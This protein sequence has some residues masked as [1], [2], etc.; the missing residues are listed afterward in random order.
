MV[1]WHGMIGQQKLSVGPSSITFL[2]NIAG[3]RVQTVPKLKPFQQLN[4]HKIRHRVKFLVKII[5][6]SRHRHSIECS[7]KRATINE[8]YYYIHIF[9]ER[10]CHTHPNQVTQHACW[11]SWSLPPPGSHG[12]N[13][14]YRPHTIS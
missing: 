7:R 8:P 13:L 5:S 6:P 1:L 4:N 14:P 12:T 10:T 11:L 3:F 9:G 2:F